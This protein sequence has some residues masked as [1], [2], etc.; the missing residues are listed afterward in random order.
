MRFK[1][2]SLGRDDSADARRLGLIERSVLTAIAEA[3]SESKGLE[4]R[5][6][7]A[8]NRAASL[9]GTEQVDYLDRDQKTEKMLTDV[10]QQLIAGGNRIRQLNEH[11]EHLRRVLELLTQ[12]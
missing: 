1:V 4:G 12:K 7:V 8:R 2:R 3:E 5:V 6:E 11:L 9:M 10:E